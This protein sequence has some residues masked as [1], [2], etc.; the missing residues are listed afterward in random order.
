MARVET[1]R[2]QKPEKKEKVGAT[3]NMQFARVETERAQKPEKKEK[4]G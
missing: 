2:V 3:E 4:L 1:E